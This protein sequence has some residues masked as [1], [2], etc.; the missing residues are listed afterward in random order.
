[1]SNKGFSHIGLSTLDLDTT[2][3]FYEN[4]LGFKAVRCDVIKIKEGGYIRHMFVEVGRDQLLAFMEPNNVDAIPTD[5]D[6]GINDGGFRERYGYEDARAS[7]DLSRGTG[8]DF[9]P[10][11]IGQFNVF[12]YVATGLNHDATDQLNSQYPYHRRTNWGRGYDQSVRQKKV[13]YRDR[14]GYVEIRTSYHP[15]SAEHNHGEAP[16]N[17]L[18]ATNGV[19][20]AMMPGWLSQADLLTPLAPVI[21][22]RSDTFRVRAYGDGGPANPNVKVWCEAI[23][24]RLPEYVIDDVK[25]PSEGDPSHARPME[26]YEDLNSNGQ[27]DESSEPFTDFDSDGT[28]SFD[29]EYRDEQLENNVNERFGR[30]FRIVKFRWLPAE[31]V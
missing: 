12:G 15:R 30:R 19:T 17:M 14:P 31:E 29:S 18:A 5:Y 27:F 3:D 24:Q 10:H 20:G 9:I 16:E 7:N 21:N 8:L 23:V 11:N 13:R 22:V 4:V 6:A 1:M 28:R 26:P 25:F 2:R